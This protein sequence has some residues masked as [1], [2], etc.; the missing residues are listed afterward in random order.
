M[1]RKRNRFVCL[2]EW[3]YFENFCWTLRVWENPTKCSE[4]NF[5]CFSTFHLSAP[6]SSLRPHA[7]EPSSRNDS[8]LNLVLFLFSPF[9]VSDSRARIISSEQQQKKNQVLLLPL[10]AMKSH[11]TR[12]R[13]T[14]KSTFIREEILLSFCESTHFLFKFYWIF[15]CHRHGIF[16]EAVSI[17][18]D[19]GFKWQLRPVHEEVQGEGW[20]SRARIDCKRSDNEVILRGNCVKRGAGTG[21]TKKFGGGN[22][23]RFI[24]T[25]L[26]KE[27]DRSWVWQSLKSGTALTKWDSFDKVGQIS[28]W[29]RK[30]NSRNETDLTSWVWI[31]KKKTTK[32]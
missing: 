22:L 16:C 29:K 15:C 32:N 7:I 21:W 24:L 19:N 18:R 10:I 31:E 30:H 12:E 28:V 14:S 26:D 3:S 4:I 2:L 11:T 27:W 23:S 17:S 20:T 5:R 25:A 6:L 1:I 8:L 13:I 9:Q